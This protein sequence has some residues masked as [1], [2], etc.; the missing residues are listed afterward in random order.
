MTVTCYLVERDGIRCTNY[1]ISEPN[2]FNMPV[3][4]EAH[5]MMRDIHRDHSY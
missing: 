5:V 1:N 3:R 4:F 2:T